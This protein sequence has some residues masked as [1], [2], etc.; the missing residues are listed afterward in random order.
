MSW[1]PA[2]GFMRRDCC[3]VAPD[4]RGHGL[5]SSTLT[6]PRRSG[7]DSGGEGEGGD[8]DDLMSLEGLAEDVTSLLVEIFTSGRLL[9]LPPQQQGRQQGRSFPLAG[10]RREPPPPA[11]TGDNRSTTSMS[12]VI[13][14]SDSSSS[15]A[16]GGKNTFVHTCDDER[17]SVL[18]VEESTTTRTT[19]PTAAVVVEHKDLRRYSVMKGEEEGKKVAAAAKPTTMIKGNGHDSSA[20]RRTMGSVA[21]SQASLTNEGGVLLPVQGSAAVAT[22]PVSVEGKFGGDGSEGGTAACTRVLLV[23]HSLGGSIAVRVAGAAEEFKRRCCGVAEISG[24]VAVD[25]VEGTALAA[26]EDMPEVSERVH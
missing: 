26:L 22:P 24:V 20:S 23:G 3:V 25:V 10:T 14:S 9:L 6:T 2:A 12:S 18:L 7:G 19:A 8:G 13:H 16:S 21:E 15:T 4:L 1:A 5:T 17:G 11:P